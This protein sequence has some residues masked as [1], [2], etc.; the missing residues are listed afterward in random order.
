M[1]QTVAH[2]L[3]ILDILATRPD[4]MT[5]SELTVA[6]KSKKAT[7]HRLVATLRDYHLVEN[8]PMG[9][10]R[11][12]PG[13][14]A[15]AEKVLPHPDIKALSRPHLIGLRDRTGETACLHLVFG[16]ER[17]CVEQVESRNEIKWVAELGRK[18]PLTAGAP[19]KALLAFLDQAERERILKTVSLVPLTKN[20]ITDRRRFERVLEQVRHDGFAISIG[21]SVASAAACA[22]PIFDWNRTAI[23]AISVVGPSER[24]S[25]KMLKSYGPL[26]LE[27][28]GAVSAELATVRNALR[29]RPV[30]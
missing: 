2:A 25:A 28:T 12:G 10:L 6:M 11:L 21:E 1:L 26:L 23:G 22:A 17:V 7:V 30:T 19:G 27:A 4:G 15:L 16:H 9:K 5:L 3:D 14:I 18:F 29:E 13:I 8:A 20:S 24:I